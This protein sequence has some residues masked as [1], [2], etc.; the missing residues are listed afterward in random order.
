MPNRARWIAAFGMAVGLL[1][2]SAEAATTAQQLVDLAHA[3]VDDDVLIALI[4]TDGST[5]RLGADD[6]LSLHQQGLSDRVI[7]AMQESARVAPPPAPPAASPVFA[8]PVTPVTPLATVA[9]GAAMAPVESV[10]A[11]PLFV[12]VPVP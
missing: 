11:V 8:T 5:F 4:E 1:A 6:I 2:V 7:R 9:P 10:I 12:P 3:G